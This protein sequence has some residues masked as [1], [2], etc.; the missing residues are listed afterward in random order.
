MVW[1]P[2]V[3]TN[4]DVPCSFF[5]MIS[6]SSGLLNVTLKIWTKTYNKRNDY[7]GENMSISL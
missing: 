3:K 6:S 5:S 7:E 4:S 1:T 2:T